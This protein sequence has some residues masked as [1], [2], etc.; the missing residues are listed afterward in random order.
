MSEYVYLWR[1]VV[2]PES[3]DEFIRHYGPDGTWVQLFRIG[4]GHLK[5]SLLRSQEQSNV[6]VTIDRWSSRGAFDRFRAQYAGEF[7]RLDQLCSLLTIDEAEIGQ[8]S[9]LA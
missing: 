8:F 9:D 7:E 5:T 6:F 2:R 1:Y 4:E 3:I